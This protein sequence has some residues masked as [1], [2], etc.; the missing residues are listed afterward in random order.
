VKVGYYINEHF[1]LDDGTPAGVNI[2]FFGGEYDMSYWFSERRC[3][4]V[5]EAEKII[6][7]MEHEMIPVH[8]EDCPNELKNGMYYK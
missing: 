1:I 4:T 7:E 8:V 5:E 3:N 6:K 2:M